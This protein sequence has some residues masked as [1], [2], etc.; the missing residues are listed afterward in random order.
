MLGCAEQMYANAMRLFVHLC[1]KCCMMCSDV[2][3]G[4]NA[5]SG[6]GGS[7]LG[8]P[9]PF[10]PQVRGEN[11]AAVGAGREIN[12]V[13]AVATDDRDAQTVTATRKSN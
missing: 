11:I 2:D 5:S 7:L 4:T 3:L 13:L 8:R 1:K 9:P 12:G 6:E 10:E